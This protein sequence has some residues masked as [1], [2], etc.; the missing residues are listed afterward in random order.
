MILTALA[1]LALASSAD[2]ATKCRDA[3][4]GRYT[5]CPSNIIVEHT[6]VT[7]L[8]VSVGGHPAPPVCKKGKVCGNSCIAKDKVCHKP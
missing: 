1:V 8:A 7:G 4:T 5:Q 3:T 6:K 2:A